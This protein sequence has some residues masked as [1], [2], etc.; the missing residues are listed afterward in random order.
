MN[1]RCSCFPNWFPG[2]RAYSSPRVFFC[3]SFYLLA[4]V[5]FP[6]ILFFMIDDIYNTFKILKSKERF[7]K[8]GRNR[9]LEAP[10]WLKFER[11]RL[12]VGLVR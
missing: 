9:G 6:A 1:L 8:S 5:F 7:V 4:E 11:F 2:L 3:L 10:H 12:F